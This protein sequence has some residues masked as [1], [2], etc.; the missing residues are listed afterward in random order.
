MREDPEK[1]AELRRVLAALPDDEES[2][3]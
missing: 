1:L 2:L 3:R